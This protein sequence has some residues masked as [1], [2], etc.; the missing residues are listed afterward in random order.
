MKCDATF[1]DWQQDNVRKV[2]EVLHKT[3]Q[4]LEMHDHG[5][6]PNTRLTIKLIIEGLVKL[7]NEL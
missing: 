6:H 5:D 4:L 1:S 3:E 7:R 2:N